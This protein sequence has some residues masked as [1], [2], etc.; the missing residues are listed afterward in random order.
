MKKTISFLVA[1]V[2]I[3]AAISPVY[4]SGNESTVKE[5]T[6]ITEQDIVNAGIL[7]DAI[8]ELDEKLDMNNLSSISE[9]EVSLLSENAR[10]FY[11]YIKEY[12]NSQDFIENPQMVLANYMNEIEKENPRSKKEGRI[13]GITYKEYKISN[14]KLKEFKKNVAYNAGFW[15]IAAAVAKVWSKSP[16]VL[17]AFLVAIPALGI[18]ILDKCN[19]KSKGIIIIKAGT[20]AT[21]TYS[22]KSQ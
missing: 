15:G 2:L 16:T 1:I 3:F 13:G 22:C 20:G 19:K 8:K 4:A 9:N 12:E 17:T 7:V 14:S 11:D 18:A 6:N 10:N 5:N 21:N